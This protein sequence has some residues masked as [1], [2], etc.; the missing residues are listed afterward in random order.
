MSLATP[1]DLYDAPELA[2]LSVL[3]DT[4]QQTI[5]AL[6]AANPEL[7]EH[8]PFHERQELATEAWV[9]D[10]IYAQASVMQQLIERYRQA[11]LRSNR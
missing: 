8:V 10:A 2:I 9:A 7:T 5:Y 3:D 11:V 4:L 6:F 1:P